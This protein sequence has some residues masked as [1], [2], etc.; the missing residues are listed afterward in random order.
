MGHWTIEQAQGFITAY[1]LP[2]NVADEVADYILDHPGHATLSTEE[3]L[4]AVSIARP[5]LIPLL[6]T[7]PGQAWIARFPLEMAG[8]LVR[9]AFRPR[10][11]SD[12]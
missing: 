12:G 3:F 2:D 10:K 11:A 7:P 1:S 9:R 8:R 6:S 5:D 4:D